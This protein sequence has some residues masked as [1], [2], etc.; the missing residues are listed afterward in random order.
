MARTTAKPASIPT[1]VAYLR[2]STAEQANGPEAQRAQIEAWAAREGFTIVAWH[3]DH[4][5]SGAASIEARPALLDALVSVADEGASVLV[6][7]KRDRLA[8]DVAVATLIERECARMNATVQTA[9]GIGAGDSPEAALL[10][11]ML[12]L[13]AAYELALIK[14]RTKAGLRAKARRGECVGEVPMGF[15]RNGKALETDPR[16]AEVV[17]AV[18]E[19]RAAGMTLRAIGA[20]LARLGYSTRKGGPIQTTQVARILARE[21]A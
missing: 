17:A 7:A 14:A 3:V 4:G 11:G 12:D 13:M 2:V 5:V 21:A 8:R 9:D 18:C 1:A 15:R 16:E 6:V 20:E 19:L 10:R